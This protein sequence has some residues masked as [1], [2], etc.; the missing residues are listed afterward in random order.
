MISLNFN[1]VRDGLGRRFSHLK[2]DRH[3]LALQKEI[4][5]NAPTPTGN[6]VVF[7]NASTR[8]SGLSLN[9]AF[10]LLSSWSLRLSGIPVV[11]YYCHQGLPLCVLG[12]NPNNVLQ[13]PPCKECIAQSRILYSSGNPVPFDQVNEKDLDEQLK[14]KFVAELMD[15]KYQNIPLGNLVLPSVRWILRK[16]HLSNDSST[17]LLLSSYIAG[18]W[19]VYISFST[20]LDQITPRAVVLFNGMSYPEAMARWTAQTKGVQV[21]THEVC[22]QPFSAFFSSGDATLR[23]I[24]IPAN[25]ELSEKQN[26]KLDVYLD[27]RFKGQFKM[28][29]VSFWSEM[30]KPDASFVQK[31]AQFKQI[32]SVFTNVI[33]DTSQSHANTIF[34]HMFAWLDM[35]GD[36]IAAHPETLFV[37]RAHPDEGRV[38]KASRESVADW[39]KQKGLD[40]AS[41]VIFIKFNEQVS[42][43]ELIRQSKFVMV[44]NSTIGLEAS[45][46]NAAVLCAGRSRF[47]DYPTVFF[48]ENSQKYLETAELFLTNDKIEVPE[49]FRLNARR[50]LYYEL[51][52]ASLPFDLFL[53][54]D[55]YWKGYVTLKN[56]S[57]KNLLPENSVTMDTIYKGITFDEPFLLNSI[58]GRDDA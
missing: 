12:T 41:N 21:F 16:H 37:L 35:V 51:Y 1:R 6:P 39:V 24:D 56:I 53:E 7:F 26:Q 29:G 23:S 42:S 14:N 25:F 17:R 46:L 50:Y 10:S 47:T 19:N 3:I 48:P 58:N 22:L 5:K 32:V 55:P 8:L 31:A 57:W 52:R 36:I 4:E 2:Q 15:F 54:E 34:P 20:L 44:Y 18:A 13:P 43:Y 11:Y 49:Q 33:F 30:E 27:Q 45:L 9:A 38:G 40:Q 28:A